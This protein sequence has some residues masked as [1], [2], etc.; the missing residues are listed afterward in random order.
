MICN[1]VWLAQ[2]LI[3]AQAQTAAGAKQLA[4][5]QQKLQSSLQVGRSHLRFSRVG[6]VAP[7]KLYDS[8][9]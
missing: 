7:S 9:S 3:A 5:L 8:S 1:S 6:H 2:E 4:E